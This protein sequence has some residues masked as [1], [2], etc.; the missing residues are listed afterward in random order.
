MYLDLWLIIILAY[1]IG[2]IGYTYGEDNGYMKGWQ[3]R[4]KMDKYSEDED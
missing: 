2:A 4:S 3:D 1:I